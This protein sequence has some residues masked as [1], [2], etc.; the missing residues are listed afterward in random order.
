MEEE[1]NKSC[2]ELETT[3]KH[4]GDQVGPAKIRQVQGE[5]QMQW[6]WTKKGEEIGPAMCVGS[7]AIW[8]K[9]AGKDGKRGG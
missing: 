5:T 8:P 1:E 6:M 2:G 9:I 7:R 3:V 4:I